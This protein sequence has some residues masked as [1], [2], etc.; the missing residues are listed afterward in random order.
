MTLMQHEFLD[1]QY[2]GRR[3]REE[4]SI[5]HKRIERSTACVDLD[6]TN[7]VIL[8]IMGCDQVEKGNIK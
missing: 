2:L 3:E 7:T 1:L 8:L 5:A 4:R 6:E